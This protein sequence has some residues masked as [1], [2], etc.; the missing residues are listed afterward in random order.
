MRISYGR[1]DVCSSDL[2]T[3]Q[4]QHLANQSICT[5]QGGVNLRTHTDQSTGNSVL[6][7][8]VLSEER[9]NAGE[10]RLD[11]HGAVSILCQDARSHQMG[12]APWREK[13][14]GYEYMTVVAGTENKKRYEQ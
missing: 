12:K 14:G 11:L 5:R 7:L 8:V 2:L 3:P 10:A 6:K 4:S 13:G 9:E 1:S